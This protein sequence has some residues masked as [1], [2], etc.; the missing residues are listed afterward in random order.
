MRSSSIIAPTFISAAIGYGICR[1]TPLRAYAKY[2]ALA[3]GLIG[4]LGIRI[5]IS[6]QCLAKVASMPNSTLRD[7]LIE[8]GYYGDRPAYPY[9]YCFW[10]NQLC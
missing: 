8:A 2:T 6:R 9:R 4:L 5:A 1:I 3:G 10:I 7:R